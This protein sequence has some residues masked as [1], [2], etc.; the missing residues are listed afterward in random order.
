MIL[1][2]SCLL[3]LC[4]RYDGKE[5]EYKKVLEYLK[6]KTYITVC[7]EQMGG[8][9]T[10]RG[11]AEI[12]SLEPLKIMTEDGIDVTGAFQKG[13]D[14]VLKLIK[15]LPIEKAILKSLSP[16]CGT[17]KIYDGTFSR[18]LIVGSGIVSKALQEMNIEV[19]NEEDL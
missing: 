18:N 1:V 10:P 3:G 12:V 15:P 8:L 6:D 7:P 14:E 5:K 17:Y 4:C 13:V 16:S 9:P 19:I 2:S 11:A